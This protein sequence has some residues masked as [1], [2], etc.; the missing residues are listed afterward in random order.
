M[1]KTCAVV[2]FRLG[3][4]SL[5]PP[6]STESPETVS[7]VQPTRRET[8]SPDTDA[9]RS[10]ILQCF[11]EFA[12]PD[13]VVEDA[14]LDSLGLD[15]LSV[16]E[17]R[18]AIA[19]M[20]GVELENAMILTNPSVGDIIEN[21]LSNVGRVS[22]SPVA[23][24]SENDEQELQISVKR[25]DP[26]AY[27]HSRAVA[28]PALFVL[29]T[30]RAGSS[31]LQLC[32]E[33][34]PLLYAPQ[35]LYL[36]SFDTLDER[37]KVIGRA[38]GLEGGLIAAVGDLRGDTGALVGKW[39]RTNTSTRSVY[40]ALVE[41]SAPRLFCDKTPIYSHDQGILPRAEL[42]MAST[43]YLS[44][45]RHPLACIESWIELERK[46][47]ILQNRD[48]STVTWIDI[49]AKYRAYNGNIIDFL[50]TIPAHRRKS[51]RYEDLV[52]DPARTLSTI[53]DELLMIPYD[54]AMADPYAA[55]ATKTFEAGSTGIA[56]TDPKLL[57]HKRISPALADKWKTVKVPSPGL[58][59]ETKRLGWDLGYRFRTFSGFRVIDETVE[60]GCLCWLARGDPGADVVVIHYDGLGF[61]YGRGL[62]I[63]D[64][65][66]LVAL[67]APEYADP[68]I[69]DPGVTE[70]RAMREARVLVKHLRG[71]NVHLV[72]Y[73]YGGP[74]VATTYAAFAKF[75]ADAPCVASVLLIDPLP[76]GSM[77]SDVPSNEDSLVTSARLF[78]GLSNK[79]RYV[80]QE[81]SLVAA[82]QAGDV[83]SVSALVLALR[84]MLPSDDAC[85]EITRIARF[86]EIYDMT[87]SW[88]A[89][90]KLDDIP[91]VVFKT[92]GGPT[93]FQSRHRANWN[94]EDGIYGWS[95]L[96]PN[97]L[98]A[99]L[100]ILEGGHFDAFSGQENL[101]ALSDGLAALVRVAQC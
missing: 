95:A 98:A 87:V 25:L 49:E 33:A 84:E 17:L 58:V 20:T 56:A 70:A 88:E 83:A 72:G 35:E 55:G 51:M 99:P 53:C 64:G 16:V 32:L 37:I 101:K 24:A 54:G 92:A 29:S 67:Q 22:A 10:A 1:E 26:V 80:D 41:W 14:N 30:P 89:L 85:E 42:L 48:A 6:Q 47:L 96:R 65:L 78:D 97:L 52:T 91:V 44:T 73:S 31:L 63:P 18:N 38:A 23:V 7:V 9:I 34:N 68:R 12:E 27:P 43:C 60:D 77:P 100:T 82:V 76:F 94:H 36:L 81:G 2:A 28:R 86:L 3:A 19:R 57:K 13:L 5:S 66:G 74:L 15:S 8:P 50:K 11:Y 39:E 61:K 75:G 62:D 59:P 46:N 40:R 93:H 71:R 4:L 90:P 79:L 45:V 69:A 21:V